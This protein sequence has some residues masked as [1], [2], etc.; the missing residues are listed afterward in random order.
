MKREYVLP[1]YT[2]TARG[3]VRVRPPTFFFFC[4]SHSNNSLH[5]EQPLDYVPPTDGTKSDEQVLVLNNERISVPELLFSPSDIGVG[6]A[7]LCEAAQQAVLAAPTEL[8]A[9]LWN[10][11]A[12]VGG[13]ALFPGYPQRV[14][15]ELRPLAPADGPFNLVRVQNPV[16]C[17]W[18][19]AAAFAASDF[20]RVAISRAEYL[21]RGAQHCAARLPY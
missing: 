1:D 6:Q 7:G 10:S 17:A 16:T 13:C 8:R 20:A 11:V 9:L 12:L 14:V 19:G 21:E 18:H 15:R 4:F 3:F 5:H 2:T